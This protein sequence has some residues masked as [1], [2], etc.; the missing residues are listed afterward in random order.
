MKLNPLSLLGI[1]FT[2]VLGGVLPAKEAFAQDYPSKPIKFIVDTSP[3]AV[4][5]IWARRFAQI[6]SEEYKQPIIVENR[7]GVSGTLAA[8]TVLKAEADGYTIMVGGYNPIVVYPQIGGKVSY[9]ARSA[10]IPIAAGPPGPPFLAISPVKGI[11]SVAELRDYGKKNPNVLTCG[12]GGVAS[13]YDFGCAAVAQA[14]D[15]KIRAIPYKSNIAAI[16]DAV[17]GQVDLVLGYNSEVEA[18]FDSGKLVPLSVLSSIRMNIR[19]NVPAFKE[20]SPQSIDLLAFTGF[21]A[22]AGTP[23]VV[24]NK[25]N[26]SILRATKL[27]LTSGDFI[28]APEYLLF[29]NVDE[30]GKFIYAE[31]SKWE[32][33]ANSFS[34]RAE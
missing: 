2:F 30:F 12:V 32:S 6:L 5:D 28:K 13:V 29:Y 26:E 23:K 17:G 18:L 19:P 9:N 25:L 24:V 3:G 20:V 31:Q 11:R 7:P 33:M 22:P 4:N 1:A 21:Y 15:I 27:M 16:T 14:L 8:Q 10:F 34:I